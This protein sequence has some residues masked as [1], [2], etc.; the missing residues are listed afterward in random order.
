MPTATLESVR[1]QI[2]AGRPDPVYLIVGDD[3][4]E[5]DGV[6]AELAALIDDELRA[7][8]IERIYAD[9]KGAAAAAVDAC[10]VRPMMGSR[11]LVYLMRAEKLFRKPKGGGAAD[12]TDEVEAPE[13]A[14]D[15][16]LDYLGRPMPESTLILVAADV[17]RGTKLG[18]LLSARATVV[19][20]WGLKGQKE[21]KG[22][23]LPEVKKRTI[24][25]IRQTL[26]RE[27]FSIEPPAAALLA[28]RTGTDMA[29]LRNDA[30]RLVLYASGQKSIT[31]ADVKAIVGAEC[32]QDQWAITTAIAA[33]RPGEAL[34][35]LA[36][37]LEAGAVGYQV[38]GQLRWVVENKL[39]PERVPAAVDALLRA[40]LALKSSGGEARVLLDRLVVELC[41]GP[42]VS[43]A[44]PGGPA[45]RPAPPWRGVS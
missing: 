21:V 20:C 33:G 10:R 12:G 35:Q 42:A 1:R 3:E 11:R 28:G 41:G 18:K 45:R 2:E 38:L 25:W 29:R 23:D 24:A 39:P 36:L 4:Q 16:L 31:V 22:W 7:F 13:G 9:Q 26:E 8:N 30:Q 32:L 6:A 19:A 34:R 40:D 5:K 17:N 43:R 27:G 14:V 44:L 15:A 37:A